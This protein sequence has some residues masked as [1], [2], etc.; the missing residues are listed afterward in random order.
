M[1][2][3]TTSQS[4]PS[5]RPLIIFLLGLVAVVVALRFMWSEPLPPEGRRVGNLCP[6]IAGE[7]ADGKPVKLS[8][9]KGKVVLV[10]FWGTWCNPCREMIPQERRKVTQ[11][12]RNRPFAILGIALDD[13][14]TLKQFLAAQQLSWLNIVD[15]DRILANQWNV[16]AVP[17]MVLVDHTGVIRKTW[18]EG[19]NP[20]AVWAAV[21]ELVREAEGK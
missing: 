13:A 7:D 15:G 4:R 2:T 8:D 6:E 17:S 19:V 1:T 16:N 3:P 18:Y 9:H 5:L 14:P 11:D 10:D 21:D 20:A 12:Y